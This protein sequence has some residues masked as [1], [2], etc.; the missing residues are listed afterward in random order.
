MST[1]GGDT[2]HPVDQGF[3]AHIETPTLPCNYV[4]SPTQRPKTLQEILDTNVAS[5]DNFSALAIKNEAHE[6]KK[7]TVSRRRS[8]IHAFF[9]VKI[10]LFSC[11]KFDFYNMLKLS[12]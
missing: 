4:M 2:N 5:N 7:G 12:N 11:I 8:S 9:K 10:N 6:N 1:K 3:V